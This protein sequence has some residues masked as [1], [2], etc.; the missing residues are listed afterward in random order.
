V[1]SVYK[2]LKFAFRHLLPESWRYPF[3]R[4]I[5]RAV[6][7]VNR[8]RRDLIV[9]NLAPV[10]GSYQARILAPVLLGNF[11]MTAVDFFCPRRNLAVNMKDDN[12]VAV[13]KAW[14]KSKKLLFVTAHM[15][16]W[17][18]GISYLVEKGFSVAGVYA[19]YREDDIVRWIMA[20]RNPEVEWIAAA[21]GAAAACVSALE[22]GRVLGMVADIPFGEKGRRV[23]ICGV[24]T[25]LPLGPWAIAS[26]AR[27]TVIP[28]FILRESPGQYRVTFCDPISPREGSLRRQMEESQ[29]IYRGHLE[30]FLRRV[31]EQWGVLQ[32]FWDDAPPQG[33][34]S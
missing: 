17:E 33:G 34:R 20:H 28:S 13:D 25:R 31:P 11:S 14:R 15:G 6:C 7:L 18:L 21:R 9:H 5:A 29:D 22:R 23:S 16:N 19:P 3:A 4:L 12:W 2:C 24:P 1:L 27:A 30:R 26:R 10:V 8:P 32:P